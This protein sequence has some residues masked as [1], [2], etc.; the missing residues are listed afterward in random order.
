MSAASELHILLQEC[1]Q[2]AGDYRLRLVLADW[3][4]DHDEPERALLVRLQCAGRIA[5]DDRL[6]ERLWENNRKRWLGPLAKVPGD[7]QSRRGLLWRIA[8]A[9]ELGRT[10]RQNAAGESA[11]W[12]EGLALRPNRT[13]PGRV[14]AP[15]LPQ[16]LPLLEQGGWSGLGLAGL[17]LG[18]PG[19]QGLAEWPPAAE[20]TV[21]D[22]S[23][24]NL[25]AD[26]VAAL[27]TPGRLR[28][29]AL[30]LAG[31]RLGP[32]GA[33][34]LA[35]SS[36]WASLASLHLHGNNL[37]A[38][39]ASLLAGSPHLNGLISLDLGDNDLGPAGAVALANSSH[40]G[41]LTFLRLGCN[42]IG[43]KGADALAG[44]PTLG[45]LSFLSLEYA[46]I[47]PAGM[48]ALAASPYL[49][50][51]VVLDLRK[52]AI[53]D[54]GAQALAASPNLARMTSLHLRGNSIG[55]AGAL[56]L[57][58]ALSQHNLAFLDLGANPID[59]G[60]RVR[61]RE[62]VGNALHF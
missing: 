58:D 37:G 10:P 4:E 52:N 23:G 45:N 49:H 39:G 5:S 11:D 62:R 1:K 32:A 59:Q 9:G 50:N 60:V 51:L 17:G 57:A 13:G 31:N 8:D 29:A 33:Q 30:D 43:P 24:N 20:L 16:L 2:F 7:W 26:G 34:V 25:Q 55:N 53:G 47:G 19:A 46:G 21:L 6:E 44:S 18:V 40:L 36:N 22:L 15:P 35:N 61:L 38:D 28:P 42:E 12:V 14:S 41:K 27:S 48:E 56:A 3:L 54:A